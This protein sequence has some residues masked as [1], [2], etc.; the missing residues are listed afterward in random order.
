L[1]DFQ[2]DT[3]PIDVLKITRMAGIRVIKNSTVNDLLPDEHGKAYFDGSRWTIIYDDRD[4]V[5]IARFTVAHELG[6]IFLGHDLKHIKYAEACEF[7]KKPKSEQQADLFAMRLLCPA[8]VLWGMNLQ[9]AEQIAEV[10]R[11][12]DEVAKLRV[13]RMKVLYHR[14]KFLTDPMEQT[15]Y[16]QFGFA[17]P[18][19]KKE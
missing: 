18:E 7:Q 2:L 6:H 8:C 13:Q 17:L 16:L 19:Q 1:T 9:T 11:V 4:P 5:P 12:P 10:C 15:L 14:G 3:V